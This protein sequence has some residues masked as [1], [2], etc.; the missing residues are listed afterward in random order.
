MRWPSVI[1]LLVAGCGFSA[2]LK[3]GQ[4]PADAPTADGP[5]DDIDADGV[6]NADDNCPTKANAAQHDED[7]DFKG[8]ECDPCP[9]LGGVLDEDIDMDGIG[10]GCDPRPTIA[11][12]VLAYW[13][14]F[15][16]ASAELPADMMMQH[17]SAARWNVTG[18]YLE[19]LATN[20]D[21]GVPTVDAGGPTHTTDTRFT[22][23]DSFPT[24]TASA[25]G[26]AVDVPETDTDLFECQARTNNGRREMWRRVPSD[27]DGW[28]ELDFANATTDNETYRIVLHR[29]ASDLACTTTREG[30]QPVELASNLDAQGNTRAGLIARSVRVRF[31]YLAVYR[32]P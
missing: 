26:V 19:F 8:D 14:G 25:A 29:T 12:D 23:V 15:H 31:L 1:A 21:W 32:S 24:F 16:V 2:E 7:M 6:N 5:P 9:H 27:L 10:N 11:G 3:S 18:G 13:N 4:A 30:D 28:V 17:G 22:I 20:D